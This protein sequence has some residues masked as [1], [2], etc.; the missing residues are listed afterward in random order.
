M[1]TVLVLGAGRVS[2]PCIDYLV[3]KGK[4]RIVVADMSEEN[5]SVISK[6]SPSVETVLKDVGKHARELIE[7]YKPFLVLNLMPPA[8]MLPV[9][10]LCLE[11]KVHMVHPAYLDA[12]T[13]TLDEMCK[14]SG[15]VFIAEL[16]L[17]P[18]I[19]HMSAARTIQEIHDAG[20][21]VESFSSYCG[22]LPAAD[23]N[24][25]PWGY[26]LSWSPASLI[27][28]S[29]RTARILQDGKDLLWPDGETYEHVELYEVPGLGA[30]EI[31]ANGDSIPYSG[32]YNIPEAK[33]I[34]RGTIRYPGWC[35]TICYMNSM[36]FFEENKQNTKGLTFG[37]FT[38]RQAGNKDADPREALCKALGLKPWSTFILRMG[39]LGFFDDRSL[40]FSEGS[41]R[42]VVSYLFGEKLI[43]TAE[44]KDLVILCDE[45]RVV[46]P[47]GK[48]QSYKSTL[49]DFGVPGKWTSIA[50]TTG[51]PPAIAARFILEGRI[52]LP[53]VHVPTIPEIYSPVLE[54]L[55]EEG[56]SLK[57][58]IVDL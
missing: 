11:K 28:A 20:G 17:D 52:T 22:A 25:N 6:R 40:P 3:R 31:Y 29:K 7:T 57:E 5:L 4:C 10:K 46:L 42:D 50:R 9:A 14:N 32:F 39:W 18:G 58:E 44:E 47:E 19:D 15:L 34:Y 26:K 35:E 41:A 21:K 38:A 1:K 30:F 8:L 49:I 12:E 24:T 56:I 43:F 36:G 48:R 54:E 33:S 2:G 45:I 51:I 53:G 27:G 55:E 16:G 13:R 37:Q 23:A